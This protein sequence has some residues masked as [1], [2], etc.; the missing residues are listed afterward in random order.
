MRPLDLEREICRMTF[1]PPFPR[2]LTAAEENML[3][4]YFD[5]LANE[6]AE[7]EREKRPLSDHWK[8]GG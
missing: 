3:R 1:E 5:I 4:N 8:V 2:A 6:Q 7:R